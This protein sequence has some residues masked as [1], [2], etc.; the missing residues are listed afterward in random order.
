M[1][2]EWVMMCR[3]CKPSLITCDRAYYLF[4]SHSLYQ[5]ITVDL[6]LIYRCLILLSVWMRRVWTVAW[7][8]LL[9]GL[10]ACQGVDCEHSTDSVS[11]QGALV[12]QCCD[13]F[14]IYILL[15]QD[16]FSVCVF[17]ISNH[18]SSSWIAV[19]GVHYLIS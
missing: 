17:S 19:I 12:N 18:Y 9:S 6:T 3:D 14:T 10:L 4:C 8:V 15:W 11:S 2:E 16:T 1:T 7:C 5:C 13:L